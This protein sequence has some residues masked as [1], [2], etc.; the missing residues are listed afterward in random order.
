M[1][2][3]VLSIILF[4]GILGFAATALL[5]GPVR[6]LAFA[7][8]AV[9]E[10]DSVR[11]VHVRATPALGGVA[12]VGGVAI[13][14]AVQSFYGQGWFRQ[15][16][17]GDPADFRLMVGLILASALIVGLG[18]V[19]DIK[20]VRARWKLVVQIAAALV[21][22][23]VG[24]LWIPRVFFI[25][26]EKPSI[27][28]FGMEVGVFSVLVTVLWIIT[29]TNAVNLIDGMDGLAGGV[30]LIAGVT[31]LV[32]ATL[33]GRWI[34]VLL[35]ATLCGAIGG[36]L[37]YNMPP[38][39]IFLGDSGSLFL[40]FMIG[41]ISIRGSVKSPAAFAFIAAILPLGL[42]MMDTI[43]AAVRRWAMGMPISRAD[44][45]HIH[46]RLS[47]WGLSHREILVCLYAVCIIFG[48]L[49][50]IVC[51]VRA[52]QAA[53]ILAAAA[54]VIL[55]VAWMLWR[56]Q[57]TFFTKRIRDLFLLRTR[58]RDHR[59][60]I[61]A[62]VSKVTNV[63]APEEVVAALKESAGSAGL[64]ELT[65]KIDA[66][67][68]ILR[69]KDFR[70]TCRDLQATGEGDKPARCVSQH[71][72]PL[73]VDAAEYGSV[74]MILLYEDEALAPIVAGSAQEIAEAIALV[75]HRACQRDDEIPAVTGSSE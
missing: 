30:S 23:F 14:L 25:P 54:A 48:A 70:F 19:D 12:I 2:V 33:M 18:I 32:F 68:S 22:C 60:E 1:G 9:D 72:M 37:I 7:I 17:F 59:R 57:A 36:F 35:M 66:N 51:M 62:L 69:G 65:V 42:P 55:V 56:R 50:L 40:G 29:C 27:S 38:A 3:G 39:M 20:P 10:P 34:V 44:R 41:A 21:L 5:V 61:A 46:H 43:F 11:K 45:E 4:A 49:S 26:L 8:G 52:P 47:D 75:L 67:H 24:R 16:L 58:I 15:R 64:M 74:S 73:L 63:A 71:G 13:A 53:I 31:I 28:L 6:R